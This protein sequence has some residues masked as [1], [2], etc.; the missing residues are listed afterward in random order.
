MFERF[1]DRA[2]MALHHAEVE[3]KN[4]G[5]D[6]VHPAHLLMGVI[7]GGTGDVGANVLAGILV[8]ALR[9]CRQFVMRC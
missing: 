2:R 5:H 3:A 6:H 9:R 1:T 4:L 7:K 8:S